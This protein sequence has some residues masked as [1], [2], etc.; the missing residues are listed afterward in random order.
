MFS[1]N[2]A[3]IAGNSIFGNSLYY[4][5]FTPHSSVENILNANEAILYKQVFYFQGTVGNKLSELNSVQEKI[6]ICESIIFQKDCPPHHELDHTVIPGDS[7]ALYLN[8]VDRATIPVA[9]LLYSFP[10]SVNS[11]DPVS[12]DTHQ[13]I[14]P[15]PG[16]SHNCSLVEFTIFA[17]E[18]ATL[19]IDLFANIGRQSVT[20]ELNTT[21][22]PPGFN[23]RS[24][25]GSKLSCLCNTFIKTKLKSSCNMSST[26]HTLL[27]GNQD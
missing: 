7:F 17:P 4:C 27:G 25:P 23:L 22:C 15:L 20:V 2:S 10:R 11:S 13:D 1:N 19:H 9:S 6:C 26:A 3:K 24:T 21:S 5:Q 12:L 16:L 8:P 14:R 18:D